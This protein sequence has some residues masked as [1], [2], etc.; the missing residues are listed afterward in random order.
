MMLLIHPP[1][2]KPSEPPA[3]I[4]RLSGML[5]ARGVE[6]RLWDANIEGLLWLMGKPLLPGQA[7]DAWT[8]RAEKNRDKNI[9]SLRDPGLYRSIDRYTK[10]VKELGRLLS[11]VTPPSISVS[12]A[13][14]E[15]HGLSPL[16][17]R[18]L[19][20]AAE[21]PELNP[22]Y[23]FFSRRLMELFLEKEPAVVGISL[24]YLSQALT[25]FSLMGLIRREFPGLKIVAGGGLITSWMSNPG[26]QNPFSGLI[27]HLIAG[28]G[29]GQLLSFLGLQESN[30]ETA[31]PDYT[32]LPIGSYLSPGLV[33]PYAAAS[34]CYWNRCGFCPEKAEANPYL[35]IAASQVIA[36]LQALREETSPALIHL[37]D[38]A[39]SPAVLHALTKNPPGPR[40]YG[41]ARVG[42]PLT[43]PAFCLSLREAGCVMLKLGIESGDQGVLDAM[44]KG[45]SVETASKVLKNLEAAGIATYVY[46]IFGTPPET[47]GAA[48]RTMEFT[49]R[50][51]GSISFLNLAIFN[52]PLCNAG[53]T[54][55]ETEGFSEGDLSLYTGF[56]HPAGWDRRKVRLFL[57]REFRPHRA[58]SPIIRNDPPVFTSNHAPFFAM[59]KQGLTG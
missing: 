54:G 5:A 16:R 3:G 48:R 31:G 13:N 57:E 20:A 51:S 55:L 36:D 27:D 34:G 23:P 44:D 30:G 37:L 53:E 28:P 45:I 43:D 4:S 42:A 18:D 32:D 33:L 7:D 21:Q 14:Y 40:W 50:H 52:M 25:A 56:R 12:P 9:A 24:N 10:V 22:F 29:E 49:A 17:S 59:A 47:E 46:L 41:F 26:W 1:V 19:L 2:A 38:N 15:D 58:I 11:R 35:P 39:V 8:R 6:H